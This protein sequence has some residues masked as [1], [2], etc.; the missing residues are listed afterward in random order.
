MVTCDLSLP[1]KRALFVRIVSRAR[2]ILASYGGR[3]KRNGKR[4]ASVARRVCGGSELTWAI[5]RCHQQKDDGQAPIGRAV[6]Q[7]FREGHHRG[8]GT[9]RVA[10]V[11]C[12]CRTAGIP[13][14]VRALYLWCVLFLLARN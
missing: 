11:Y 7:G 13:G 2:S 12:V 6:G 3:G 5:G 14:R 10:G 8:I 9:H 1:R 4:L